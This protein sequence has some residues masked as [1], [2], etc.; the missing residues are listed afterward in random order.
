MSLSTEKKHTHEHGEQACGCQEGQ[1]GSGR[2]WEFG[3]SRCKLLHLKWI[4]NEIMLYSSGN[5]I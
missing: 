1:G 4:N 5:Y 3:V 2:D